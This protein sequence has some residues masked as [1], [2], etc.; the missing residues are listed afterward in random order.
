MEKNEEREK[1]GGKKKK[2]KMMRRN[3]M[4]ERKRVEETHTHGFLRNPKH[5][6]Y[7]KFGTQHQRNSI[8]MTCHYFFFSLSKMLS[9]LSNNIDI[10]L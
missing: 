2:K 3:P 6:K 1:N 8:V 4:Y 5:I 9:S 7:S 10:H